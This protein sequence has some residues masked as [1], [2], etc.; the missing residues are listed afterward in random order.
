METIFTGKPISGSTIINHAIRI[1]LELTNDEYVLLDFLDLAYKEK[2]V[3]TKELLFRKIGLHPTQFETLRADLQDRKWVRGKDEF[4]QVSK[5]WKEA[6][7][8]SEEDFNEFWLDKNRTKSDWPGNRKDAFEKYIFVRKK[9]SH[10]HIMKAKNW[11]FRLLAL[12][13]LAYREKMGASVFLNMKTQRFNDNWEEQWREKTGKERIEEQ[14]LPVT[15]E[16]KDK[17]F[18]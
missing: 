9:F 6:F 16:E 11:Y 8:I 13:E 1:Q 3:I 15:K 17:L 2:R 10:E 5:R 14:L 4:I 18:Q 7:Y 12:P